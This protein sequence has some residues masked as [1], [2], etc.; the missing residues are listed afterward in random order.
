M[1][2]DR[3]EVSHL[4]AGP[5]DSQT[6]PC[7]APTSPSSIDGCTRF[8]AY[9]S[10]VGRGGRGDPRIGVFPGVNKRLLKAMLLLLMPA[11]PCGVPINTFYACPV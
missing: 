8:D 1:R 9:P 2:S 3:N 10:F 11:A 5:G 6:L 4:V 7:R